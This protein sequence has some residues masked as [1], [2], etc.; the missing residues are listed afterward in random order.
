MKNK[1]F[2][3]LF[4][5]LGLTCIQAQVTVEFNVD[6]NIYSSIQL[7]NPATDTV[8]L[9]GSF[10]GWQK[11]VDYMM[12]DLDHDGVYSLSI[13]LGESSEYQYKYFITSSNAPNI[14]W[15]ENDNRVL[16]TATGNQ[17]L[18]PVYFN[19]LEQP[20]KLLTP[21][22]GENLAAGSTYNITWASSGISNIKLEY[23]SNNGVD[24]TTI[25]PSVPANQDS[26]SWLVPNVASS[27]CKV[28]IS[29][30]SDPSVFNENNYWF[31]IY[32][33][34][35][36]VDGVKDSFYDSLTGP[37]DGY[38]QI[39]SYAY[40]ENGKP[41]DNSDLSA[42]IWT[43][44]DD[45]WFY[46][47]EEVMDDTVSGNAANVWEEDE[48]E[49]KFDPQPNNVNQGY[50]SV[51][52]TRLTALALGEQDAVNA[53]DLNPIGE[54]DKQFVRTII[55]GGYT[56]EIAIKWSAIR[57]DNGENIF[58]GID[59]IFGL[60]INQHDNDGQ[61]YRQATVQ[62]AVEMSD[63][64]WNTPKYLGSVK[65]LSNNKLQFIPVNNITGAY[66]P[67]PYD[68]SNFLLVNS[69]NGSEHFKTG[70][71]TQIQWRSDGVNNINI[72][73]SSDNGLSWSNE[74][75]NI[76][77]SAGICDWIIPNEISDQCK[78][79]ITDVS[80]SLLTDESD[81]TFSI[82][83]FGPIAEEEPNDSYEEA[84]KVAYE[85]T[86]DANI[87]SESDIDYY[88]INVNSGDTLFV[89]A[90]DRNGSGLEGRLTL[91]DQYRNF[92]YENSVFNNDQSQQRV[93]WA[94][95]NTGTYYVRFSYSQNWN[96]AS[97]GEKLN[98]EKELKN[99]K[100]IKPVPLNYNQGE[101]RIV[102]NYF[103]KSAP[104]FLNTY[105]EDLNFNSTRFRIDIYPNGD[106]KVTIDYGT[107]TGYGNTYEMNVNEL[108]EWN[109]ATDKI[110]GLQANQE[111][112][113]KVTL[114]NTFGT[115]ISN[116][117]IFRTPS[118]PEGWTFEN[119][120]VEFE[121]S[122]VDFADAN[123]GMVLGSENSTFL[124][125]TD[126]GNTWTN[127]FPDPNFGFW[128]RGLDVIDQNKIIAVG[129]DSR[130]YSSSDA[131]DTW[132]FIHLGNSYQLNAVSFFNVNNGIIVNDNGELFK[133]T[134][135]GTDWSQLA[136]SL[137]TYCLDIKWFD[138]NKIIVVDQN[139]IVHLSINAGD[140]WTDTQLTGRLEKVKFLNANIGIIVGQN[141]AYKTTDGGNSWTHLEINNFTYLR[142]IAFID[143]NTIY[144]LGDIGYLAKS[145]NGGNT[146]ETVNSGTN[147][148]LL[149]IT[150]N[151]GT[152]IIVGSYGTILKYQNYLRIVAPNG[153]EHWKVG[154]EQNIS[155]ST[156]LTDNI[157]IDFSTDNGVTWNPVVAS[158]PASSGN[159]KWTIPNNIGA[160]NKIKITDLSNSA[161]Y[162]ESDNV[163]SI[164]G[165]G[166]ITEIEPDNTFD[167]AMQVAFA[168]TVDANI[169]NEN[170]ID[171]YKINV[172]A[173]DTLVVYSTERNSSGLEGKLTLY[174]QNKNYLYEI[175]SFNNDW[176]QQRIVWAVQSSGTYYIRFSYSQNW[177]ME[178]ANEKLKYQ[179]QK[180]N[181]ESLKPVHLS[182]NQ[183][184]YRIVFNYF[185]KAAPI[186]SYTFNQDLNYN[187]T[188]IYIQ[189]YPNGLDTKV[190]VDYGPT[191]SYG[192]SLVVTTNANSLNEWNFTTDK[193][194]SLQANQE[195][196]FKV[197]LQNA[198]GTD[199]SGD[200]TFS[201]PSSPV[202]WSAQ[203]SN[204]VETL[205]GVDFFD[206]NNGVVVG[207]N[208]T[209]LVT[210]DGG[211]TWTNKC[212][213]QDQLWFDGHSVVMINNTHIVAGS[214]SLVLISTDGGNSWAQKS[215]GNCWNS[216]ISFADINNGVV[217][218]NCGEIYKTTDGGN[219]WTQLTSP[220]STNFLATKMLNENTIIAL[221]SDSWVIRS[222]D[223]G[224]LWTSQQLIN[225]NNWHGG[226]SFS[227]INNGMIVLDNSS[228]IY[229]TTDSGINWTQ[230]SPG[231]GGNFSSAGMIDANN[232][233]VAGNTILRTQN[234]GTTWTYE[235][236]GTQNWFNG[237][238]ALSSGDVWA[239]GDWGTILHSSSS[240]YSDFTANLSVTD[241]CSNQINL[242]FGT[243]AD[244]TNG[245]D[246]AYDQ[247]AP[248]TPPGGAFDA[249]LRF[250]SED[251][252]K[253]FR[254]TNVDSTVVWNVIY[255]P[256]ESCGPVTLNWDASQFPSTGFFTLVDAPT[257]GTL[258]NVNMRTTDHYT[259]NLS[260]GSLQIVFKY[261]T[262]KEM[263]IL[264][265]WNMLGLPLGVEDGNYQTLYPNS[266]TG[267]LYGFNGAYYQA[268]EFCS[269]TG[270]WL[271][272]PGAEAV[273]IT[274]TPMPTSQQ[275]SLTQG[276][277]MISGLSS[278]ID[279]N[280]VSDP[281][282]II[283]PGTLYG[284]DG[285]YYSS[286]IL[287]QGYG[288]WIRAN[289]SGNITLDCS[290]SS[291]MAKS[292]GSRLDTKKVESLLG[293][294]NKIE[295][296]DGSGKSI[297]LYF[298]GRLKD[299][300]SI[301]SY[302]L[303]PIAPSE[304]FDARFNGGYRLIEGDEGAINIQSNNYPLK[305]KIKGNGKLSKTEGY[306]VQEL[307]VGK[308]ISSATLKEE[309]ELVVSDS[310]IST[311][312][313]KKGEVIPT[314]YSLEQNYPNPFN[315]TTT[316]KFGL[317]EA[318]QVHIKVYN[319]LGEQV[320][321]LINQE[322]EAGYHKVQFNASNY[323]SGVY[324]YRIEA[325][326]FNSVKKMIIL[327]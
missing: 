200:R 114:Q 130:V 261:T 7:F 143:E 162:D 160:N 246:A 305:V 284:F 93:V 170:D 146:W 30:A 301:E 105:I 28:R 66:N 133:T 74:K 24:W 267:T 58:P 262:T 126:E 113:Y 96:M 327:K 205:L 166:I 237:M 194:T 253:D 311:L 26:Y 271:R 5:L 263:N 195:Y 321:E 103:K 48:L 277:N 111:Y 254:G 110:T 282:G 86:V 249:R 258:V 187:S 238:K 44:W 276:W 171:Y 50:E 316:I 172:S 12:D 141:G 148:F 120:N 149:D 235:N 121:L 302:S 291:S 256:A 41:V 294:F 92:L 107:T 309:Q 201:T 298:S 236:T 132:N 1:I 231:I 265:G 233:M 308:E 221:S 224:I 136:T 181:I 6:M 178:S 212:P 278:D 288:Y 260:I 320:T 198:I 147:N 177:N 101:Y 142:S 196:H 106:T 232:T 239:V 137:N 245:F 89:Y 18:S 280:N 216:G 131:G 99:I 268:E 10:N 161:F 29:D 165:S 317:P 139:G 67:I 228:Y 190:T 20:L 104:I 251:Y 242:T 109:N 17:V 151:S 319:M 34:P 135:G 22:N 77:A 119:S 185:Q 42:K 324:F 155:W 279:L 169:E 138:T 85:D 122:R 252:L 156:N 51:F 38:L 123:F 21:L 52:G 210:T 68:G 323:A 188:R 272:F 78:I 183:G 14:G 270:Y 215:V 266:M 225:S 184:E 206:N 36:I 264:S 286:D 244:A 218:N 4:L 9:R 313:I 37:D 255:Q 150:F 217:V 3:L 39:R 152:G 243:A 140:S 176:T 32:I 84:M 134:N 314:Q 118:L 310:K 129:S 19:N 75:T 227:D 186:F 230:L 159:Y 247:Y 69:P 283:I 250:N 318:A 303:P 56:L 287:T 207:F 213:L 304:A 240:S 285:T 49:L 158:I 248:P 13:L 275:I 100:S 312:I 307:S 315:P 259:D 326:K 292:G 153:G 295:I 102:F 64:V 16:Q 219:N 62:W 94:V 2:I 82:T 189:M 290:S 180:K 90:N 65:F 60:A 197:A 81:S 191:D 241:N 108:N 125:T 53:D 8:F 274:G 80:N 95:Q 322:M 116:D 226:I 98:Y 76:P 269:C 11:S 115:T 97:A 46:L 70:T 296:T 167:Q 234:G 127:K 144:V 220:I 63:A 175:Q 91:Y 128:G 203:A 193:I 35:V 229:K 87:S 192:N 145:T 59:N 325:G 179:K 209:I 306:V 112:H 61:G 257:G 289:A 223:G 182:S 164:T 23:S 25:I 83:G 40:N 27:E 47:Y 208:N 73:F 163:F 299:S 211:N 300:V 117:N 54:S 199:S 173:G 293:D 31:S 79:K 273:T 174:N 88:K 204:T 214:Y 202:G 157:K 71:T 154:T 168:D 297:N 55:P 281:G 43:A 15:E 72:D 33:P 45:E 124:I 57:S 222:T